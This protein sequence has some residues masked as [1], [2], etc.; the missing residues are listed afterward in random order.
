MHFCTVRKNGGKVNYN[1][2]FG[3]KLKDYNCSFL[4]KNFTENNLLNQTV[5]VRALL[6]LI[7]S[8]LFK[9]FLNHY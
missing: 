5:E 1:Q 7:D 9:V 8:N 4:E 2:I 3:M 6:S